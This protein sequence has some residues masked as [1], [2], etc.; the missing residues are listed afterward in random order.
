MM[1]MRS[2]VRIVPEG[3]IPL[4]AKRP[5]HPFAP[6]ARPPAGARS[7]GQGRPTAGARALPLTAASTL[8]GW[9]RSGD[10]IVFRHIVLLI[11]G[12]LAADIGTIV[13]CA[14]AVTAERIHQRAP[15]AAYVA[16]A[17]QRFGIPIAWIEAV[18]GAESGG[19]MHAVS[20]KGAMGLMQV[21]P[22]TWAALRARYHLGRDP[23]DQRDNVM[24]GA[25]YLREMH[26]RYGTL[27][28]M[29]AAYNGGPA[30]Y[31]EFL[32][33]GRALPAETR[34]YV[35]AIAPLIGGGEIAKPTVVASARAVG[36]TRAPLFVAQTE[37]ASS[38]DR[39]S[40]GGVPAAAFARD[41]TAI[42]PQSGNLFVVRTTA[43]VSR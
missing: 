20:P 29:L 13:T 27:A 39:L 30:R 16:E 32:S 9:R 26:D 43:R 25:A 42:T 31:D 19:D 10:K 1:A 36:W 14:Q 40:T 15:Y 3:S 6:L 18:L 28:G 17:A 4:F 8:A 2:S 38:V 12:V 35:A 33:R 22:D 37:R 5:S 11:V 7:E 23:Y 24:A 41:M 21:M 34:A